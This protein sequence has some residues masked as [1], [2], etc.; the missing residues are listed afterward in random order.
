[1]AAKGKKVRPFGGGTSMGDGKD[2]IPG[3]QAPG[4]EDPTIRNAMEQAILSEQKKKNSPPG[5]HG[6]QPDGLPKTMPDDPDSQ[7]RLL[8]RVSEVQRQYKLRTP[9]EAIDFIMKKFRELEDGDKEPGDDD[10][11]AGDPASPE[12]MKY[13]QMRSRQA[14]DEQYRAMGTMSTNTALVAAARQLARGAGITDEES[15]GMNT[16]Q[17]FHLADL[18]MMT[19]MVGGIGQ[20][21]QAPQQLQPP[22]LTGEQV[23]KII[24]DRLE[25]REKKDK[26]ADLE[27]KVADQDRVNADLKARLDDIMSNA[28]PL[29]PGQQQPQPSAYGLPQKWDPDTGLPRNP[30]EVF[31]QELGSVIDQRM[32]AIQGT[33]G[34]KIDP[35]NYPAMIQRLNGLADIKEEI[36][37]L[38]A[39]VGL[40]FGQAE[41]AA[42]PAITALDQAKANAIDGFMPMLGQVAGVAGQAMMGQGMGGMHGGLPLPSIPGQ[43]P[44][45][46]P[47]P[48]TGYPTATPHAPVVSP[49]AE[50]IFQ[51]W[52]NAKATGNPA[53]LR[54]GVCLVPPQ[55]KDMMIKT[56]NEG[57]DPFAGQVP[58]PPP[59]REQLIGIAQ[60]AQRTGQLVFL[61]DGTV[62][63]PGKYRKDML[64]MFN[65]GRDPF[66]AP[67][68]AQTAPRPPPP[69]APAP[70]PAATPPAQP[71]PAAP[72]Q[73]AKPAPVNW[74]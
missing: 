4:D 35:N 11:P 24:D 50:E 1:M 5:S 64:D 20:Q 48:M 25:A 13:W 73:P 2:T 31:K 30:Y 63:V 34:E 14:Q 46:A 26:L 39:K 28:V 27:K 18:K 37:K 58:P 60:E 38:G 10:P 29:A 51:R 23:A 33:A 66:A 41:Q 56:C 9:E 47:G 21:P 68:P 15:E 59:T 57:V 19:G 6:P 71:A 70:A 54:D 55:H 61:G 36:K 22:P 8:S 3:K 65:E 40:S 53:L 17:I 52:Q 74:G 69:P 42:G 7:K 43:M 44:G 49:A 67:A 62:V 45:Q 32:Q 72:S 12:V 16:K